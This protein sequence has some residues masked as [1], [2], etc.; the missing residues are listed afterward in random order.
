MQAATAQPPPISDGVALS[1]EMLH[2]NYDQ[3]S[4]QREW[5]AVCKPAGEGHGLQTY[6]DNEHGI[7]YAN[8]LK[9]QKTKL[10]ERYLWS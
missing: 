8:P 10:M 9:P 6:G 1:H 7:L 4:W 3:D 5:N 2:A